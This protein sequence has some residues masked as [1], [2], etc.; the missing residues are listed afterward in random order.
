MASIQGFQSRIERRPRPA[1]HDSGDPTATICESGL[2]GESPQM[3]EVFTLIRQVAPTNASVLIT[4]ESGTGKELVARAIHSFSRRSTEPFIAINC[5][6]MPEALIE[7]ELFGHERGA[8][9]GAIERSGGALEMVQGGTLLLD[10]IGDMPLT[11]QSKLLRVLEDFR[12]RRLGG[13]QELVADMRVLAATNRAPEQAVKDGRLREDL[14]YRLNVFHIALPPLRD[15][16]EDI[17][18][19]VASLVERLNRR[20]GTRITHLTPDALA[21]L[22]EQRWEGNVRELR[23]VIERAMIVA[24][25]GAVSRAHLMLCPQPLRQAAVTQAP[26]LD[27]RVG[28]TVADGERVLIQATMDATNGN[29]TRAALILSISTKTLYERLK[30]YDIADKV[31]NE[32]T[33]CSE[34]Q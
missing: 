3:Q 34:S 25:E 21:A 30:L 32:D 11:M 20:H 10:E 28:M 13:K 14:Y 33:G 4:G 27:V 24:S 1:V 2:H 7:R 12:Y 19:I 17:S 26:R 18:P 22:T 31:A 15:R 23:N 6:A 16:L 8:F 29:K 9:T 5:A